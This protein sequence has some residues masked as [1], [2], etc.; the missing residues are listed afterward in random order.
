MS[1]HRLLKL[2]QLV[3][4]YCQ[5]SYISTHAHTG[6]FHTGCVWICVENSQ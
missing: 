3:M 5:K 2:T 4:Y 6:W 1:M